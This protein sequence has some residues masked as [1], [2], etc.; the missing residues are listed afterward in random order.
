MSAITD[1]D[2]LTY[3]A[4]GTSASVVINTTAKTIKLNIGGGTTTKLSTDGVTGQCLYSFL[5][6]CWKND[7]NSLNLFAF[8]FPMNSITNEQFEFINGWVP[9]DD[10]T[11]K[12]I[13]TAGWAEYDS[14]GANIARKYAGIVTLGTL[15]TS[16]QVYYQQVTN[17]TATNLTYLGAANEAVQFY[18][19]AT[20]D[21]TTTTFDYSSYFKIFVRT[22]GKTY[23]QSNLSSIGVSTMSYIVYRF[24]LSNDTDANITASDATISSSAPYTGIVVTYYASAQ[25]ETMGTSP[26]NFNIIIDGNGAKI[27]QIYQKIQYLLR[28]STDIDAGTG[29]VLGNTADSLLS[30]VGNTLYSSTGVFIT[31]FSATDINNVVF[32][33]NTGTARTFPY[34]ASLT[35]NYNENLSNDAN[36]IFKIFFTNDSAA[37]TPNGYNFG[38]AN[39]IVVKDASGVNM[40]G[41]VSGAT[42]KIFTFDYDGNIQRGA[43]SAGKDAPITVVAIGLSTGQYVKSTGTITKSTSNSISLV[44]SLERNYSN[45][46]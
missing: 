1:P 6:E 28:Q 20:Y 30:F 24:P 12:L 5:K 33:D 22:Q 42:S 21:A 41:S 38:T 46:A 16:D 43:G 45:L 2:N 27:S 15:G 34:T 23:S 35:V 29:T 10:S 31:N 37:T 7:A 4:S 3:A 19:N 26:Y 40:S 17:G 8:A 25:H 11:R 36:A 44:S 39:A 9:A 13:R 18:G 32:L 14:T